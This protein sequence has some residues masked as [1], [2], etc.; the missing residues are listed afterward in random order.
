MKN[1]LESFKS[2]K[3]KSGTY[4]I[5]IVSIA[6]IIVIVI[7]L[8][9]NA[10]PASITK[11]D[12]SFNQLYSLTSTTEEFIKGLQEDVNI[13]VMAQTGTEDETVMEMLDNYQALSSHIKVSTVDP[14]LHPNFIT[15]YTSDTV[16][17]GALVVESEKR[18]MIID[19]SDLYEVSFDYSTYKS[20]TTGFDGEGQI[21]S[22]INYV[23]TNDIPMVYVLTGHN[24]TALPDDLKKLIEK[25]SVTL[26]DFSLYN[27]EAVPEDADSV[28]INAPAV[29]ISA[30]E[31]EKLIEYLEK[32]GSMMYVEGA[33][34]VEKPNLESVLEYYGVGLEHGIVIEQNSNN[35][36][37]P[38]VYYL[39]PDKQSHDIMTTF[40]EKKYNLFM[41]YAESI[42]KLD[43]ARSTVNFEPLLVTSSDSF[44][45][46]IENNALESISMAEGD[47]EGPCNVAVAVSEEHGDVET[48]MVIF[49][50]S[51][52]MTEEADTMVSGNNFALITKTV[53]WL[54]DMD[55]SI[56]IPAK[57]YEISY[58]QITAADVN[59]WMII[60]VA[61]IPVVI[62]AWGFVV[63]FRRRRK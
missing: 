17:S 32:G 19:S 55:S 28:I 40:I 12:L 21:T 22:A 63:W 31:A 2:R 44:L 20:Q 24:E 54:T 33:S 4:S 34:D 23:T 26:Q 6:V 10:L 60:T 38:Y 35:C 16:S 47:I 9:V 7:N 1:I 3:F 56:A 52:V 8:L 43:S 42:I 48:R 39:V 46:V 53:G 5:G 51:Y 14:V 11:H 58:L 27:V 50:T 30:E 25:S 45:R 61:V 59:R 36:I 49:A 62:L 41:P 29:D 13:Y 15:Q 57:S 37:Y 18:Y